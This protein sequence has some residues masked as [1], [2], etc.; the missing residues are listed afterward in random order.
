MRE[1]KIG[2]G[3]LPEDLEVKIKAALSLFDAQKYEITFQS[4][5]GAADLLIINDGDEY[6]NN[7]K[8]IALARDIPVLVID[9]QTNDSYKVVN[10][11]LPSVAFY[12]S[13]RLLLKA[14]GGN[15]AL[16]A[17]A[18]KD[19]LLK[20]L[21]QSQNYYINHGVYK[22]YV[23]LDRGLCEARSEE[24]FNN[25][26]NAIRKIPQNVEVYSESVNST[27]DNNTIQISIESYFFQVL[28][29]LHGLA[30]FE[31]KDVKLKSW[32]NI[33]TRDYAANVASLSSE[34]LS[35][36]KPVKKLEEYHKSSVLKALLY[37]TQLANLLDVTSDESAT[38]TTSTQQPE[39]QEAEEKATGM[40][41]ALSRW[42]GS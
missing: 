10:S 19:L 1:I 7:L 30:A 39:S 24:T 29:G 4:W 37:A 33:N 32:P 42:L 3:P 35:G 14:E 40:M 6:S 13:I 9:G 28:A 23:D 16:I 17:D 11:S 2:S 26:R 38:A 20:L 36:F 41:A 18:G 31:G 21:S 34:L 12:K 22:V 27:K 8:K 25:L 5:K 15:S